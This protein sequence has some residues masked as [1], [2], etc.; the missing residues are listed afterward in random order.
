MKQKNKVSK[1]L[2]VLTLAL[3]GGFVGYFI[4]KMFGGGMTKSEI[5]PIILFVIIMLVSLLVIAWHEAGH[6]FA[7]MRVGFDFRMYVVGPFLW[8][9]QNGR[10]EFRWNKD[11][12]KAGGLVLCLPKDSVDLSRRFSILA[13]A[14]PISSLLLSIVAYGLYWFLFRNNANHFTGFIVGK[15]IFIST[16]LMSLLIFIVTAIPSKMGGLYSDGARVLR[17]QR[18]GDTARFEILMMKIIAETTSGTRPK[19]LRTDELEEV[20]EIAKRQ[21]EPFGVYTH[22]FLYQNAFDNGDV[23]KAEKHLLD[24]IAEAENIPEGFRNMVW[25]DAAFFYAYTQRNY[26]V[27]EEYWHQFKPSSIIPKAQ[28]LATEASLSFLKKDFLTALSK[29]EL[30][31][32]EL[33]NMLDKG[34]SIAL[35]EKLMLL[36]TEIE[37]ETK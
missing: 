9:R 26:T 12:N 11:I 4:G 10:W 1:L 23:E 37:S 20:L 30:A 18:G 35:N 27:A 19:L 3:I 7:G 22:S 24:Y 6:A 28:I 36:K 5:S 13:A 34:L 25:L 33:P 17:F 16:A 29:I 15:Y 14:G 31:T 2:T 21:N 32:K 8:E